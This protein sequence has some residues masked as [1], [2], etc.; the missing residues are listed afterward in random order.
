MLKIVVLVLRVGKLADRIDVLP[1][2]RVERIFGVRDRRGGILRVEGDEQ[3]LGAIGACAGSPAGLSALRFVTTGGVVSTT[4]RSLTF[5][6]VS[7]S[8]GVCE[9]HRMRRP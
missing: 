6:P 2:S 3:R 4:N 7:A 1:W 5:S 8:P 9:A